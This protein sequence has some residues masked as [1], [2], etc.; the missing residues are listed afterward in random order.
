MV[1][2]C[3][4]LNAVIS[5]LSLSSKKER[6]SLYLG[7]N[8]FG[9]DGL[10]PLFMLLGSN[11]CCVEEMNLKNTIHPYVMKSE[12]FTGL[13]TVTGIHSLSKLR[14]IDLSN[15]NFS[16]DRIFVLAECIRMCQ[17][18]QH[19][20][21]RSCSLCS[22]DIWNLFMHL[23]DL[24]VRHISLKRWD[25]WDNLIDDQGV[26]TIINGTP[27]LFPVLESISI[28]G[29][30]VGGNSENALSRTL[31]VSSWLLEL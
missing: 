31:E 23:K 18:L 28:V 9:V 13:S 6:P 29:N 7:N 20:Y 25:H 8:P 2:L 3:I 4:F 11:A 15:N 26:T 22:F 24:H 14:T 5:R 1:K 17:S 30:P 10:L 27:E 19:L 16:E 21:C 12:L